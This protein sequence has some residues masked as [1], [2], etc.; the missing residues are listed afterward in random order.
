MSSNDIKAVLGRR[1]VNIAPMNRMG[2][3]I[4]NEPVCVCMSE[5][6]GECVCF[7]LKKCQIMY[8]IKVIDS[9]T[10]C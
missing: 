8:Y 1:T 4:A 10:S 5:G 3:M 2:T 6:E 9:N 7:V